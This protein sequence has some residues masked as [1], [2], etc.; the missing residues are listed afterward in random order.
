M[1]LVKRA[2]IRVGDAFKASTSSNFLPTAHD[3][4]TSFKNGINRKKYVNK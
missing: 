2:N 4:L 3:F 1:D